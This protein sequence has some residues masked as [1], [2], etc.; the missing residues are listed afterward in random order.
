MQSLR[1]SSVGRSSTMRVTC[2]WQ[3]SRVSSW[4][5]TDYRLMIPAFVS[6]MPFYVLQ[7][8]HQYDH[9]FQKNCCFLSSGIYCTLVTEAIPN[10]SW[11]PGNLYEEAVA[12]HRGFS[13]KSF[14]AQIIWVQSIAKIYSEPFWTEKIILLCCCRWWITHHIK[15]KDPL[16][17]NKELLLQ[18]VAYISVSL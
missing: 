18:V 8:W 9:Y 10:N 14:S 3:L 13:S 17:S 15:H 4:T 5:H 2:F 6:F 1:D 16:D 7:E 12:Y 11:N